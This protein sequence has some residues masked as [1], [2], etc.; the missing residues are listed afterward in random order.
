MAMLM[1]RCR[2]PRLLRSGLLLF[3]LLSALGVSPLSLAA[4][5]DA[6]G[7]QLTVSANVAE[8]GTVV[9]ITVNAFPPGQSFSLAVRAVSVSDQDPAVAI[10]PVTTDA[11]GSGSATFST[12][13]L[14]TGDYAVSIAG[15]DDAALNT[16]RALFGVI[17]PGT[18]G[19]RVVH[20]APVS[21]DD[22]G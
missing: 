5:P 1:L 8:R 4:Y 20:V 7:P 2:S 9:T 6:F 10:L 3:G 15:V 19:P 21:S 18:A 11:G 16:A 13:G 12:G 14:A 22:E 17:D